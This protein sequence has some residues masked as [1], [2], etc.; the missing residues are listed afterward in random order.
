MSLPEF[1]VRLAPGGVSV[2]VDGREL[3]GIEAVWV[4]GSGTVVGRVTLQARGLVEVEGVGTVEATAQ[5]R[6]DLD[7]ILDSIDPAT[8]ERQ[9]LEGL[10]MGE[11]RTTA[12][13]FV[14]HIRRFVRG[15]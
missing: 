5:E 8:L 13:L 7:A 15:D 6:E 11:T 10:E 9:V 14:E 12:E 3:P 4:E 1:R 2:W